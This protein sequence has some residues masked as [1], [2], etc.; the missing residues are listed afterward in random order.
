MGCG[1]ST[2]QGQTEAISPSPTA[3]QKSSVVPTDAVEQHSARKGERAGWVDDEQCTAGQHEGGVATPN[4]DPPRA[5]LNSQ[6]HKLEPIPG[7]IATPPMMSS[8][9]G[10]RS[11]SEVLR[12]YSQ[13]EVGNT[14]RLHISIGGHLALHSLNR[15][16]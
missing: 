14:H 1:A 2:A 11:A 16:P 12:S 6:R 15:I 4:L 9:A 7:A 5:V 10:S 3:R 13:N 8:M